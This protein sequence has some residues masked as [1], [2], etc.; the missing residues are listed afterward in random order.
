[1][2]K[3]HLYKIC[4]IAHEKDEGKHGKTEK[5][6]FEMFP[7]NIILK[8]AYSHLVLTLL[9]CSHV[10]PAVVPESHKVSPFAK[11]GLRGIS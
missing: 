3:Y 10:I 4:H 8:Y 7:H 5:K 11:G 1:M 6:R 2:Q 9:F